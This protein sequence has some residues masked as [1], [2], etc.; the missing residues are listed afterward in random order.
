MDNFKN[1]VNAVIE[2]VFTDQREKYLYEDE[3]ANVEEP[4]CPEC[5]GQATYFLK[6]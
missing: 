5:Q 6:G 2:E 4:C 1:L 3:V